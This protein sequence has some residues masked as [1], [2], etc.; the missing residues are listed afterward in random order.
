MSITSAFV[1]AVAHGLSCG[2]DEV[3]AEPGPSCAAP[4]SACVLCFFFFFLRFLDVEGAASLSDS[5]DAAV[6]AVLAAVPGAGSSRGTP[7]VFF[8]S[9][10]TGVDARACGMSVFPFFFSFV[11]GA[12]GST[13]AFF[14]ITRV[15][16]SSSSSDMTIAWGAGRR[17][18]VSSSSRARFL[19]FPT[20]LFRS[21]AVSRLSTPVDS[22]ADAP[23]PNLQ[24]R[25]HSRCT[26]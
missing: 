5:T 3:G 1:E 12:N 19:L 26:P 6:R 25:L 23:T 4:P 14:A 21:F 24:E 16:L 17:P 15:R 13:R 22:G 7:A 8:D 9:K 11:F 2:E 10:V 18:L 20:S